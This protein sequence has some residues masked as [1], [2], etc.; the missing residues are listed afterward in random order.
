MIPALVFSRN[1]A[2]QLDTLL[3]SLATNAPGVF[4][5]TVIYRYDTSEFKDGYARL[6]YLR[7]G[8]GIRWIRE[9]V[10]QQQV[11]DWLAYAATVGEYV[12][13]FTDD[14]ILY[15]PLP[16]PPPMGDLIA[17]SLRLGSNTTETYPHRA[18][19][20]LPRFTDGGG[21]E[22]HLE[23]DW[24]GLPGDWGYVASL[25]G[26]VFARDIFK[27]MLVASPR[28]EWSNP[29]ELEDALMGGIHEFGMKPETAGL[30]LPMGCFP[31]SVL[32]NVP[33][34]IVTTSHLTNRVM[35]A[36]AYTPAALNG[37]FLDGW[38]INWRAMDYSG[39]NAAH[40]ELAFVLS[41]DL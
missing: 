36:P 4:Q 23:W 21:K 20:P 15:R 41:K 12:C 2:C 29:N 35:D 1:R 16:C 17:F 19:Y 27:A 13:C 33:A 39:V 28:Q 22:A 40:A 11:R 25:D 7:G 38:R 37:M 32:V 34:N 6:K 24:R 9:R 14:D 10:F 8:Q 31:D 26:H 5:P 18:T 3:S 30:F